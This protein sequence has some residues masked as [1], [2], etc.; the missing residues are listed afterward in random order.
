MDTQA[1]TTTN[2]DAHDTSAEAT[3]QDFGLILLTAVRLMPGSN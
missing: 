3:W 1:P 2:Q